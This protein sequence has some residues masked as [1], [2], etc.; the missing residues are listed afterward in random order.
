MLLAALVA[1]VGSLVAFAGVTALLRGWLETREGYLLAC[2]LTLLSLSG[3]LGAATI[4]LTLDFNPALVRTYVVGVALLAILWLALAA[5]EFVARS[6]P[7]TFAVRLLVIS[8]SIVAGVILAVD[9]LRESGTGAIPSAG[10]VYLQL[11]LALL[12]VTHGGVL[13]IIGGCF[14]AVALRAWRGEDGAGDRFLSCCFVLLAASLLFVVARPDLVSLAPVLSVAATTAAAVLMWVTPVRALRAAEAEDGDSLSRSQASA[15]GSGTGRG[16]ADDS[17]STPLSLAGTP[18]AQSP[19]EGQ[20]SRA[21]GQEAGQ[22]AAQGALS[23]VSGSA[24]HEASSLAEAC[25]YIVILTLREGAAR[26][27][28]RLVEWAVQ[29]I[30]EKEPGTLLYTCHAV[31]DAP[32]QRI[33]YELYRDREAMQKHEQQ[34]HVRRFVAEREQYVLA[35]NVVRLKLNSHTGIPEPQAS[36]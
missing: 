35:T 25:G 23:G 27:F 29:A 6:V 5:V 2:A 30:H 11:P 16:Q 13:L 3:G 20:P 12:T 28:D 1:F 8:L 26:P 7:V 9:P 31:A 21:D 19:G 33:F 32:Q 18:A 34:P 15:H 36:G 10:E 17:G 24:A 22:G 14:F 4:G